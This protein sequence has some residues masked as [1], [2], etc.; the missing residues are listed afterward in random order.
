[1]RAVNALGRLRASRAYFGG[2]LSGGGEAG[3]VELIEPF[4]GG[5]VSEGGMVVVVPGSV[6]AGADVEVSGGGELAEP[7]G[8]VDSC[9][10]QAD[11]SARAPTHNNR[12]LRFIKI[13]SLL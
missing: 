13:T 10:E 11:M 7:A 5:V 1:V 3:G 12:I 6:D 4:A 9:L 2:V 8:E